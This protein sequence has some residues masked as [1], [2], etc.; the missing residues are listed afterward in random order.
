MGP[1]SA[2]IKESNERSIRL[3]SHTMLRRRPAPEIHAVNTRVS[4]SI[5]RC[6]APTSPAWFP[7]SLSRPK[8][9]V[10]DQQEVAVRVLHRADKQA[11]DGNDLNSA[12]LATGPTRWVPHALN[13]S[14]ARKLSYPRGGSG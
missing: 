7:L 14:P 3:T 13:A 9:S 6:K 11:A 1:L 4:E 12:R 2:T 5:T 10:A 8:V